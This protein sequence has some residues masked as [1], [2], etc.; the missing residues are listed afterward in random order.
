MESRPEP[1]VAAPADAPA[2]PV[3]D[4]IAFGPQEHRDYG[5]S[6]AFAPGHVLKVEEIR[7]RHKLND[8]ATEIRILRRLNAMG[9]RS[10][11]ELVSEGTWRGR[12]YFISRRAPDLP[13]RRPAD[14]LLAF[15]EL[16]GC[17]VLHGDLKDEN[18]LFNGDHCVLVDLDQAVLDPHSIRLDLDELALLYTRRRCKKPWKKC[19]SLPTQLGRFGFPEL[20]P[21]GRLDLAE[22]TLLRKATSTRSRS[23]IYH[24]L[25]ERTVF[26]SGERGLDGRRAVLDRLEFAGER[27]LDV[28]CNTG[29]LVRYL[30]ARGAARVDGCEVSRETALAGEIVNRCEGI[31]EGRIWHADLGRTPIPRH[32]DTICLF[33]VLHHIDRMDAAIERVRRSCRRVLIECRLHETGL[34]YA[35]GRWRPTNG[36]RFDGWDALGAFLKRRFARD[37]LIDHGPVDR[38]R[39]ILELTG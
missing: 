19:Q 29:L 4:G 2:G 25:D 3:V 26:A 28:G 36:W 37:R 1:A 7:W 9:C 24:T 34:A 23:G 27:V 15:L 14:V 16:K 13:G 31:Y 38:D 5:T 30:I 6:I 17:G 33:S 10:V 12:R 35:D 39:R 11:P 32:Y 20:T 22:T 8:M 21:G 18:V